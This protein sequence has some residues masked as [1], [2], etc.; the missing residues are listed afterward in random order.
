MVLVGT[1]LPSLE[2]EMEEGFEQE[3]LSGNFLRVVGENHET[4]KEDF[5]WQGR[6][7]DASQK[8]KQDFRISRKGTGV[9]PG[10]SL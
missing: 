7:V 6:V 4:P 2:T 9:A 1:R 8:L 10:S 5:L 3:Q